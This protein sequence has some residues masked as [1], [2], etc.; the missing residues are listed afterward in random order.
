MHC[1]RDEWKKKYHQINLKTPHSKKVNGQEKVF[2]EPQKQISKE[3]KVG[4]ITNPKTKK[5][6]NK[7]YS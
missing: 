5:E 7:Y 6:L 3:K 4:L 2:F 1:V